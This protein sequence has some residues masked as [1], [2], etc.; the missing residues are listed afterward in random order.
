M[1]MEKKIKTAPDAPGVYLFKDKN[2]NII[3]IG[4]AKS[5]SKRVKS[6]FTQKNEKPLKLHLLLKKIEDIQYITTNNELEAILLENN[7]IKQH[8]PFYNIRL[9]DDKT[10]PYLKLTIKEKFPRLL[11]TRRIKKDGNLYYGPFTP[12]GAVKDN[13]KT[14]S[15]IFQVCTCKKPV[16]ENSS[17][18]CLNYQIGLCSAPC[19]GFIS[20]DEYMD[21]VIRAKSFLEGKADDVLEYFKNKMKKSAD[22][23]MFEAAVRYRDAISSIEKMI[24]KQKVIS[25]GG[26]NK[27][28]IG[29][30]THDERIVFCVMKIRG[31]RLVGNAEYSF[32]SIAYIDDIDA[33]E[34]FLRRYYE[35]ET[36]IP[37]EIIVQKEI[38]DRDIIQDWLKNKRSGSAEIINPKKGKRFELIKMAHENAAISLKQYKVESADLINKLEKMKD[39]LKLYKIPERIE[40]I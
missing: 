34:S 25:L 18:P 3:Y 40:G 12:V 28:V 26:K 16:R 11:I 5:V 38:R 33:C 29:W 1:E 20:R 17:R 37:E 6:Y 21:T 7:L 32:E 22:S 15:K 30:E 24:Q 36:F 2:S 31:G 9:K 4:K 27:D 35:R 19:S 8:K 13:L 23:L 14:L 39:I 10:Y